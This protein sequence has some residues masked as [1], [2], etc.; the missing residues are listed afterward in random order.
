MACCFSSDSRAMTLI[1]FF[2]EQRDLGSFSY[3]KNVR[4][5]SDKKMQDMEICNKVE[6]EDSI[7]F[8][9]KTFLPTCVHVDGTC[10]FFFFFLR[11]VAMCI[12]R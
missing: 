1:N 6:N 7:H 11:Y 8:R 12:M 5:V 10:S 9:M 2:P 3:S 4:F